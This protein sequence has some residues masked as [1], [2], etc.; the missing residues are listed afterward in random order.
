M[1]LYFPALF[2]SLLYLFGMEALIAWGESW[3]L[4]WMIVLF[5]LTLRAV[6]QI[7]RRAFFVATPLL[8]VFSSGLLLYL[9]D[10]SFQRQLFLVLG[11][12]VYYALFL[13]LRRISQRPDDQLGIGLLSFV[14]MATMFLFYSSVYGWYLNFAI[15]VWFLMMVYAFGTYLVTS[16]YFRSV[17]PES[18]SLVRSYSLTLAFV[19][20][21]LAWVV[22]F[23]PFGYLT[24]GAVVLVFY[25]IL[26]DLTQSYFINILSQKRVW[27][28]IVGLGLLALMIL[29]SARWLP[30]V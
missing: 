1:I 24:T 15:P 29:A 18:T 26:W 14:T 5:L 10:S 23:W 2:F 6:F 3:V 9:I 7:G 4:W 20:A 11:A 19:M 30:A 28:N 27:M 8:F 25:Y 22:N 17:R 21:E 13:G 16:A 12:L